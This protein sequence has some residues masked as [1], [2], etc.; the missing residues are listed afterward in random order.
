MQHRLRASRAVA[1]GRAD[2][3][4]CGGQHCFASDLSLPEFLAWIQ[5]DHGILVPSIALQLS[6]ELLGLFMSCTSADLRSSFAFLE[7]MILL[8]CMVMH[9]DRASAFLWG[10]V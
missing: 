10:S 1:A 9:H 3:I 7:F 2:R 4:S 5:P 6:P 8:L